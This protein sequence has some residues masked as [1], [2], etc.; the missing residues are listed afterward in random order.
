LGYA[1]I[2]KVFRIEAKTWQLSD[3]AGAS[4]LARPPALFRQQ[5]KR[6]GCSFSRALSDRLPNPI[7]GRRGAPASSVVVLQQVVDGEVLLDQ[8]QTA[9]KG[10]SSLLWRE[11]FHTAMADAVVLAKIMIDCIKAVVGLTSDDV[12]FLA[13]GVSLPTNN[14]LMSQSCSD[15]VE[16]GASWD[17]GFG[18]ALVLRQDLRD[19]AIADAEQLSQIAVGEQST[20]FVGLLAEADRFTQQPL[21]SGKAIDAQLHVLRGGDVEEDGDQ[22]DVRDALL[23]PGRIVAAD[24]HPKRLPVYKVVFGA[25]VL[26]DNLKDHIST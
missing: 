17:D 10:V 12:R 25:H 5:D 14:P 3:T 24:G 22:L 13:F 7:I 9:P 20:L 8:R 11:P 16:C 4:R 15:V 26:E 21:G 1:P 6:S 18:E 23:P 2:R 19:P